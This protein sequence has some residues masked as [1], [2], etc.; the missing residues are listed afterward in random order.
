M[1]R[2][3][4]FHVYDIDNQLKTA[5]HHAAASKSIELVKLLFENGADLDSR[6]MMGRTPLHLAAKNNNSEA[7]RALLVYGANPSIK[8]IAGKRP[9]E[10]T[11]LPVIKALINNA[12]KVDNFIIIIA[13]FYDG[14]I[15][16]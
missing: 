10:M 15:T 1:L 5:L 11:D 14:P 12:R 2:D 7:V 4:R 6:D 3:C 8:T 16:L 13:P 9:Y